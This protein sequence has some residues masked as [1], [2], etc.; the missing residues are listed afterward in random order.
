MAKVDYL[1]MSMAWPALALSSYSWCSIALSVHLCTS[2]LHESPECDR[3]IVVLVSFDGL[4]SMILF[5]SGMTM[6]PC[7]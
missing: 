3:V 7:L 2:F 4:L 6:T 1:K 5:N